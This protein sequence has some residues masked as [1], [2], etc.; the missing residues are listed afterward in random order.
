MVDVGMHVAV[1]KQSDKVA[2]G[3][4][5]FGAGNKFFPKGCF[6][7]PSRRDRF[8]NKLRALRKDT[9]GTQG[10]MPDFAVAH[11]LIRRHAHGRSV[12]LK[13][14]KESVLKQAVQAWRIGRK[15]T[16]GFIA[17]T[18]ADPIHDNEK[19]RTRTALVILYF[20]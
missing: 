11:I 9:S 8:I 19:H 2:Y 14:R 16:V 18:Q 10:I 5:F 1:G 3:V 20:L 12:G 15:N 7:N 13:R 4:F 17:L 6:K